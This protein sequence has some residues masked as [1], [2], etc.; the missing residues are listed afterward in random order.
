MPIAELNGCPMYYEVQGSGHPLVF[1]HGGFG[2]A[3]TGLSVGLPPWRDGFA[4][5]LQVITYDRRSA[6]RSGY[7]TTPHTMAVLA[8]DLYAL[9]RHLGM[10]TAAV[11]GTS[12]GGPVVIEFALRHPEALA[13]LVVTESAPRFFPNAED[14]RR[15]RERIALLERAG[16]EAAYEARRTAGTVGLQLFSA[17]RPAVSATDEA[18]RQARQAAIQ[19]QLGALT[20]DDRVRLYAGEL[21]N[22]AAYVDYNATERLSEIQAPTLVINATGDT[23]FPPSFVDW[24]AL[25]A[26]MANARYVPRAGGEHGVVSTD[27]ACQHLILNF[28]LEHIAADDDCTEGS[29]PLP[30]T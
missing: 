6:G 28:I 23:I 1:V 5:H 8:D 3:G 17:A 4:Q 2:G 30:T 13:C 14:R 16:P 27:E 25:T 26:G 9:L 22:Y 15:L 11:M 10:E 12:A 19:N 20:R 18:Q 29:G 24:P 21:R 7:P